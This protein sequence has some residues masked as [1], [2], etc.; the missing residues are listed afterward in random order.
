MSLYFVLQFD[1]EEERKKEK[2]KKRQKAVTIV[3]TASTG[4]EVLSAN[5]SSVPRPHSNPAGTVISADKIPVKTSSSSPSN[6]SVKSENDLLGLNFGSTEVAV[7]DDPFAEFDSRTRSP[8]NGNTGATPIT[9]SNCPAKTSLADE[10]ADFF[11]QKVPEKK[12]DKDSILKMFDSN[13]MNTPNNAFFNAVAVNPSFG[14]SSSA[15]IPGNHLHSH[16]LFSGVQLLP[17]QTILT[18]QSNVIPGIVP[19]MTP[20]SIS[21]I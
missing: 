10:E 8:N 12:L 15:V 5:N 21:Q 14:A 6:G 16:S 13:A 9:N 1:V 2:E 19:G 3:K 20:A 11:N 18:Q 4:N 17:Q 7:T